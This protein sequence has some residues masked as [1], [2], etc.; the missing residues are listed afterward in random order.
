MTLEE[1]AKE[2]EEKVKQPDKEGLKQTLKKIPDYYPQLV[3]HP[4]LQVLQKEYDKLTQIVENW[5]WPS[6]STIED[7]VYRFTALLRSFT[8]AVQPH[9]V[10]LVHFIQLYC[11]L[12]SKKSA[13]DYRDILQDADRKKKIKLP[14][15]GPENLKTGKTRLYDREKL[16]V[17][18]PS[19]QLI[20]PSLPPLL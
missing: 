15:V 11:D 10:T 2:L 5:K 19:Y 6:L 12:P 3:N 16:I 9:Y 20:I 8:N 18:W 4:N 7:D 1:I 17:N 14:K 13:E